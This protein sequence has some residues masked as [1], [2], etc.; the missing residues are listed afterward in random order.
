MISWIRRLLGSSEAKYRRPQY[1]ASLASE[2][3]RSAY[4]SGLPLSQQFP[5]TRPMEMI[6]AGE[7]GNETLEALAGLLN[8]HPNARHAMRQLSIVEQTLALAPARG[9]YLV[10]EST[11]RKAHS[12]LSELC[13]SPR[14]IRFAT[15]LQPLHAALEMAIMRVS[16]EATTAPAAFT[17]PMVEVDEFPP[18]AP[19]TIEF[20]DTAPMEPQ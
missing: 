11:L 12:Q 5:P 8:L 7:F 6:D 17:D 18:F 13:A 19:T 4:P 20:A 1:A 3:P 9:L 2:P 15:P 16:F 10:T 14:G